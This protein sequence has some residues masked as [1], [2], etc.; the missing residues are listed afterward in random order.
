MLFLVQ[1]ENGQANFF[2]F[3]KHGSADRKVI[4]DLW[5]I[6]LGSSFLHTLDALSTNAQKSAVVSITLLP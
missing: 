3:S 2:N 6:T 4:H 1:F 5:P